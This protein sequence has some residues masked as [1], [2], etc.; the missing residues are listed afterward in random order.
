VL[1]I[2]HLLLV[3]LIFGIFLRERNDLGL[4]TCIPGICLECI[5]VYLIVNSAG[6]PD[7]DDR[8]KP[9]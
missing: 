9:L 1:F 5:A 6:G 7:P 8:S 4:M 3:W 2:V